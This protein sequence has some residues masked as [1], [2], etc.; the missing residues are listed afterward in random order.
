MISHQEQNLLLLRP[1]YAWLGQLRRNLAELPVPYTQK[2]FFN[3][4]KW[5]KFEQAEIMYF[6]IKSTIREKCLILHEKAKFAFSNLT[7][8]IFREI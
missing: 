7:F 6:E 2:D 8:L 5:T 3:K 1:G 4:L